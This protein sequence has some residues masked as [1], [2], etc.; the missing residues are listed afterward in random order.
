M[1]S[2]EVIETALDGSGFPW[3]RRASCWSVAVAGP[4]SHEVLVYPAPGGARVQAVLAE[5][6]DLAPECREALGQ[7]L[8]AARAGLRA[9]RCEH[10]ER[11]ARV[12]AFAAAECLDEGLT[13][14]LLGVAAGR[15]LL[16]REAAALLRPEVAKKYLSCRRMP[17]A[18]AEHAAS[19]IPGAAGRGSFDDP[20]ETD[21]R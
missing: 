13:R 19:D 4:L 12:V 18:E 5:W 10:D 16:A 7:F 11:Q 1:T 21:R 2:E 17:S 14:A 3:S 15:G 6:D 8:L 20:R 9:A